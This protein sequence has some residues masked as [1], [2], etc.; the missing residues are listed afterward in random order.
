MRG[1]TPG[2]RSRR[3][4]GWG[5]RG[6]EF[7]EVDESLQQ[8][9]AATA[10]SAVSC[11]HSSRREESRSSPARRSTRFEKSQRRSRRGHP[12]GGSSVAMALSLRMS[13]RSWGGSGR[14]DMDSA[15]AGG[16]ARACGGCRR[17]RAEDAEAVV[18]QAEVRQRA[19]RLERVGVERVEGVEGDLHVA[20]R[21]TGPASPAA[22]PSSRS[23]A[24][25]KG[26]RGR[27]PYGQ[28]RATASSRAERR[29]KTGATG[30]G[31]RPGDS[32]AF[33]SRP[34]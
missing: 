16:K 14:P 25:S 31:K 22:S 8:S 26:H 28:P 24:S 34:V 3:G 11:N 23:R 6:T 18:R 30:A 4:R 20:R 32:C 15:G 2:R 19:A 17:R 5:S 27:P 12:A 10:S 29:A 7:A 13:S 9:R 33:Q 1:R 21:R